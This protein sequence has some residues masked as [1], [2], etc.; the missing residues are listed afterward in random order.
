M[1][2]P[3]VAH[4]FSIHKIIIFEKILFDGF[5]TPIFAPFPQGGGGGVLYSTRH[6]RVTPLPVDRESHGARMCRAEISATLCCVLL[7]CCLAVYERNIFANF[8]LLLILLFADIGYA[9][10]KV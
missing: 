9:D 5:G 3:Y 7:R 8:P 10:F 4:S 1:L 6:I 2:S